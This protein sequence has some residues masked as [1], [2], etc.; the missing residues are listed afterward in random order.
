[1]FPSFDYRQW[2]QTEV[3]TL[4]EVNKLIIEK[5]SSGEMFYRGMANYD[6]VCVSTFYRYF[7]TSRKLSWSEQEVG[8]N[9]KVLLPEIDMVEYKALSL[10]ILDDFYDNLITLGS[11]EL[12][13]NSI[14]YLAQHYGLPTDLIDFSYDP[15]IP[16][17]FACCEMPDKDFSIYMFDIY[18]HVKT[19]MN[20]YASG[21]A[22]FARNSDGSTMTSEELASLAKNICTT[23]DRDGLP[24]VTPVI[25]HDDI[26]YGQRILNQKGAF[27]YHRDSIPMDQ[28]MYTASSETNYQGRRVYKINKELKPKILE[29]LDQRY[30]INQSF[31][32][33]DSDVDLNLEIIQQAVAKTK[34]KFCL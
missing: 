3:N 25:D 32:Y 27:I 8:Y 16:L 2:Y 19:M 11:K 34:A 18:A 15:K 31:V 17:Y 28:L 10:H 5:E 14:A 7:I 30:G 24:T 33:P 9:S 23:I 6:F 29:M 1:M 4:E 22:G 13:L 21:R 12:P 26:K 20:I